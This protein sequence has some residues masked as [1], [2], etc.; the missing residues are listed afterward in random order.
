MQ[1]SISS[2]LLIESL[3]SIF[4]SK[5]R[6]RITKLQLYKVIIH[7][8]LLYGVEIWTLAKQHEERLIVFPHVGKKSVGLINKNG[9]WRIRKN[10]ELRELYKD[11]EI[12][13][14]M[15]S[16]RLIRQLGHVQSI[17]VEQQLKECRWGNQWEDDHW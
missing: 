14:L 3:K 1:T 8:V 16:R 13:Q 12:I 9:E 2:T 6:T 15:K 4:G 5:P 11:P 10:R 17:G 7:P